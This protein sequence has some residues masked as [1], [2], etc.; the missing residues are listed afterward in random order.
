MNIFSTVISYWEYF[1]SSF[2]LQIIIII[3]RCVVVC[4]LLLSSLIQPHTNSIDIYHNLIY[5][6]F[7]F[8]N[9]PQTD[10][11]AWLSAPYVY[12]TYNIMYN[13]ELYRRRTVGVWASI[14]YGF[15]NNLNRPWH[16]HLNSRR[17]CRDYFLLGV[18]LPQVI[19]IYR[20]TTTHNWH[21][22]RSPAKNHCRTGECAA[23]TADRRC[24]VL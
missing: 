12:C 13:V 17:Q 24:A 15:D 1:F 3:E 18:P 2:L 4:E 11:A 9:H 6:P 10:Q 7:T 23:P 5:E 8:I 22:Y 21:D 16:I 14:M 20:T 19:Y